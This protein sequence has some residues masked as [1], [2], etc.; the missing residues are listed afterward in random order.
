VTNTHAEGAP[1][2][3]PAE[4]AGA[5]RYSPEQKEAI[6][7]A[8]TSAVSIVT[9]GPGTG[10]STIIRA[11]IA[12]FESILG[13]TDVLLAAPTGRAANRLAEVTGHE[14]KTIHRLLEFSPEGASFLR[15]E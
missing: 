12:A 2:D 6:E 4:R 3:L 7:L 11:V 9:G 15:D 14:A 1:I 10:K 5:L 13:K 8:I